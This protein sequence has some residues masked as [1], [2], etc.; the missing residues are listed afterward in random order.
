MVTFG[1]TAWPLFLCAIA[2]IIIAWFVYNRS[3]PRLEGLRFYFLA[4]LRFL[5]LFIILSLLFQPS[6]NNSSSSEQPAIL[7]ILADNSQSLQLNAD[8]PVADVISSLPAVASRLYAFGNSTR[9]VTTTDS[10]GSDDVRTNI[11][12]ALV[13]VSEDLKDEHLRGVLLI[14]DGQYNTG[15][16]PLYTAEQYGVPIHTVI[17]GD[18]LGQRDLR[19]R[20]MTTNELGYVNQTLPVQVELQ[21]EGFQNETITLSLLSGSQLLQSHTVD[22]QEASTNAIVDFAYTPAEEGL[23]QLRVVVTQLEGE[24]TYRNNMETVTVRVLASKKR[25]LLLAAGPGPDLASIIQLLDRVHDVDVVSYVQKT[26]NSFYEGALPP[27]LADF[28]LLLLVGFPGR[29]TDTDLQERIV[30]AV[31]HGLPILF[32]VN[33]QTDIHDLDNLGSQLP[34]FAQQYPLLFEEVS[35]LLT[36]M[37]LQHPI[38]DIPAIEEA[39]DRLPPLHYTQSIWQISPDAHVLAHVSSSNQP[40]LVIRNRAG[41]RSAAF[42]GTGIWRWNNLPKDFDNHNEVWPALFG[43][44]IQWLSTPEDDRL[45]RVRPTREVFDG[46]ETIQLT[47]QVYDESLNPIP[48]ALLTVDLIISDNVQYPH[49]M[50]AMGDGRYIL[51]TGTLPEGTYTYVA[52]ATHRDKIIDRDTGQFTVGGL[53]LEFKETRANA[54][55]LRQIARRSGGIF[56]TPASVEELHDTL[57]ADSLFHPLTIDN[58]RTIPLWQWS[59]FLFLTILCI[60]VEWGLRK[61]WG[62]V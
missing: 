29:N 35:V 49:V 3:V 45:L 16:N 11:A 8:V 2:A 46:G 9:E 42:L 23:H 39:L 51:E 31:T 14:T 36:P 48:D 41:N 6:C 53:T 4:S 19:V 1:S 58:T 33:R 61:R 15:R 32:F 44:L 24:I 5:A 43:N 62:L 25:I 38:L 40:L 28:D 52:T 21:A 10:L 27:S 26:P 47:G 18:T 57:A 20:R 34:V 54:L 13:D 22:I 56:M 12:G 55:L 59:P 50:E 7:A 17:M 60:S 37:G 30:R